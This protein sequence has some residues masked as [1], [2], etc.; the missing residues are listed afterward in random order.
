MK[1]LLLNVIATWWTDPHKRALATDVHDLVVPAGW[2]ESPI[3]NRT[4][5]AESD[6]ETVQLRWPAT[7]E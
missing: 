5:P 2:P 7:V 3:P 6:F 1:H 4:P